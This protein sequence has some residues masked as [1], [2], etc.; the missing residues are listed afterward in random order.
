MNAWPM[1]RTCWLAQWR[2]FSPEEQTYMEEESERGRPTF[3]ALGHREYVIWGV[4]HF[5]NNTQRLGQSADR[6]LSIKIDHW[7]SEWDYF[8]KS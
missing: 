2:G 8:L 5:V 3:I 4:A 1:I 6:L 7:P